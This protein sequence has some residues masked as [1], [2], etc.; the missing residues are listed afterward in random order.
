MRIPLKFWR[1]WKPSRNDPQC[2]SVRPARM[3]CTIWFTRSSITR[4]TRRSPDTVP[5]VHVII[6]IDNSVTVIDNG[7]G[8][9][10]EIMPKEGEAGGRNQSLTLPHAGGKFDNDCIQG[11]RR[12]ARRRDIRGQCAF[13]SASTLKSGAVAKFMSK[14]TVAALLR[15]IS[16]PPATPI[17]EAP[18]SPSSRMPQS[19]KPPNYQLR[20]S[21][22][23]NLRE[24]AFLNKGILINYR[25]SSEPRRSTSFTTP[26]ES[27]RLSST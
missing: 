5:R 10:T 9:L 22:A 25:G 7:R 23:G 12:F 26:A 14:P 16:K 15:P 21:F 19:S 6:H 24:L 1:V 17:A 3:T 18:K 2:T 4:S 13:P 8:I 20:R 27:F 11:F